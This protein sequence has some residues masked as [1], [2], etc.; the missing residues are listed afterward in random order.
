[1]SG[2]KNGVFV[3]ESEPEDTCEY[4]GAHKETRPYGKNGARI[5]F[6]CAMKPEN[7]EETDKNFGLVLRGDP[8]EVKN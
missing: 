3:I 6:K 2:W 7:K 5:C 4:C 1:M 8:E